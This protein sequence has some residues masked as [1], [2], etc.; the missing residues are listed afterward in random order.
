ML[1]PAPDPPAEVPLT[2]LG[3]PEARRRLQEG[4]MLVPQALSG[5]A[6]VGGGGGELSFPTASEA[7]LPHWE[8]ITE[9]GTY[10]N[11][12]LSLGS[13]FAP[14]GLRLP[15]PMQRHWDAQAAQRGRIPPQKAPIQGSLRPWLSP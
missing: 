2:P 8:A 14:A 6:G 11:K 13:I 12:Q 3:K 4:W 9:R 1:I 15:F 10:H 5:G 7:P